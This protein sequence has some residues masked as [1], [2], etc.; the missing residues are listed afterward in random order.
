M[1]ISF[2][3]YH[4]RGLA[5]Y[6]HLLLSHYNPP[7]TTQSCDFFSCMRKLSQ[8]NHLNEC[9]PKQTHR[10]CNIPWQN[11]LCAQSISP[12]SARFCSQWHHIPK[13]CPQF[14]SLYIGMTCESP[15]MP[16]QPCSSQA[17][18]DRKWRN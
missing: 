13:P 10:S 18:R 11:H 2:T 6:H 3:D 9:S 8:L 15:I 1:G 5:F 4:K 12:H 14:I 16:H 17:M 7:P